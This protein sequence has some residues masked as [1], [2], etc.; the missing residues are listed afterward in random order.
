LSKQTNKQ[1]V[2]KTKQHG[3]K[4]VW[5]NGHLSIFTLNVNGLSA[6]IKRHRIANCVKTQD[7]IIYC[8][9]ETHLTEKKKS[10]GLES[11]GG[12]KFSKQMDPINRQ[13]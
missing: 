8:L 6:P 7:L 10:I 9:Q 11:K 5:E 2:G 1:K 13:D 3:N 4:D 12:K